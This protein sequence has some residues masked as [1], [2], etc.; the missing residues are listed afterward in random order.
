MTNNDWKPIRTTAFGK[1]RIRY[2]CF[3]K[4]RRTNVSVEFHMGF[5]DPSRDVCHSFRY[6]APSRASLQ[7]SIAPSCA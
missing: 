7:R 1:Q 6:A 3:T 4:S 5:R 2:S